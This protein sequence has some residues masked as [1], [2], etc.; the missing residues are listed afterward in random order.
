MNY[1][2]PTYL[3]RVVQSFATNA[4]AVD[5]LMNFDQLVLQLRFANS[6]SYRIA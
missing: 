4:S 3:T 6:N 1:A 5:E 2:L